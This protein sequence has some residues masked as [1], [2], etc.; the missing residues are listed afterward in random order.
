[1]KPES[2]VEEEK[3]AEST[4]ENIFSTDSSSEDDVLRGVSNVVYRK[5]FVQNVYTFTSEQLGVG[6]TGPIRVVINRNTG[7]RFAM[8]TINLMGYNAIQREQLLQEVLILGRLHHPN[9][10]KLYEVFQTSNAMYLIQELLSGGELYTRLIHSPLGKFSEEYSKKIVRDILNAIYYLHETKN[11]AHRDLKLANIMF[12]DTSPDAEIK[13]I[14]FGLS[15]FVSGSEYMHSLVGTRYYIAPEVFMQDYQGMGYN[16][17][18]DMWS[19]GIITY[20]M[21]TGHNPLPATMASLPFDQLHIDEIP[22]PDNFWRNISPEAISFVKGLLTIDPVK[23]MTVVDAQNHPWMKVTTPVAPINLPSSIISSMQE[24]QN[25]NHLKKA[26][27]TA[28]AYHLNNNDLMRLSDFFEYFDK[29]DDGWISFE[30]FRDAL[31]ALRDKETFAKNKDLFSITTD[32]K[33]LR[34]LF[35]SMDFDQQGRINYSEFM[36]A[37]LARKEGI[38]REYAELIFKL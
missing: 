32:E 21:L 27:L 35:D 30:E 23:R 36:A 8:K 1:M 10:V 14:D 19:I 28:V 22:F 15:K 6:A 7:G 5:D 29:Q 18:C 2:P 26:A 3:T 11:I 33:K 38:H 17:S 9:I 24:F 16:K 4:T 20:F 31:M 37:C 34:Q 13:L 12:T 25:Y